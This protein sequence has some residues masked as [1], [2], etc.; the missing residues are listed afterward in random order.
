MRFWPFG[1]K[2]ED[3]AQSSY[4]DTVVNAILAAAEAPSGDATRT[5]A[6]ESCAALYAMAFACARVEGLPPMLE[7]ALTPS[8]L[9]HIARNLIRRGNA[10]HVIEM[11]DTGV[12]RLIPAGVWDIRGDADPATWRYRCDL[13]GPSESRSVYSSPDGVVHCRYAVDPARPWAGLGPLQFATS[14]ASLAGR[15]ENGLSGEA[16]AP[17]A[18]L[19]P[20]PSD[21]GAGGEDD[22]LAGLKSDIARAKGKALLVESTATGWGD[23]P[24]GAP[25]GDWQQRRIGA[26][27]PEVLNQAR[28]DVFHH[29]AGACG[30]PAVLLNEKSEGTSQREGLRR[31]LHLSLEPLGLLVAE[32]LRQKLESPALAFD[33]SPLM[34]SDL[35]GRARAYKAFIESGV[36]PADA[37][38]IVALETLS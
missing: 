4:S 23:G 9:A 1:R 18:Q 21:G 38:R 28:A 32:E 19:I 6:L 27:W 16:G 35:A 31:F 15:L 12:L 36:E 8:V 26:H 2:P 17:A 25:K 11:T 30:V 22:P 29:V 14:S 7:S 10:V 3:R 24:A 33:F 20:I 34:A 5:A 13:F 37:A